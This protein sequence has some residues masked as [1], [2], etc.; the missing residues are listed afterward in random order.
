MVH[1][2]RELDTRIGKQRKYASIEKKGIKSGAALPL[3][4]LL[5]INSNLSSPGR[6]CIVN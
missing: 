2:M 6:P 5:I 3:S 1:R 4:S